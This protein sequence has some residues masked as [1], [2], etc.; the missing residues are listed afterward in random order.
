MVLGRS[1]SFMV[2]LTVRIVAFGV[3]NVS[4]RSKQ[5]KRSFRELKGFSENRDPNEANAHILRRTRLIFFLFALLVIS[6][7]AVACWA[8]LREVGEPFLLSSDELKEKYS[9]FEGDW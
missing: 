4:D 1:P 6:C 8:I 2:G 9:I 7:F 3:I 5:A